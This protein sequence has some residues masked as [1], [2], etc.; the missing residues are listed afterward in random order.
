[1]KIAVIDGQGGGLG[2]SIVEKIRENFKDNIEI[3]ALGTNSLATSNMIKGGAHAGA[4]GE[5]AIK[6]MSKK[7][8]IIIGP[9]A[10][11]VSNAMMGEITPVM[12]EHVSDSQAK[13]ILLPMNK[14]NIHI[15]GTKGFKINEMI[16]AIIEELNRHK[17]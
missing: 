7:V 14:C 1:M 3:I 6:V 4:T 10:I 2:R 8:D 13:K 16:Q 9:I 11:I 12:A 5:N 15:V 17:N